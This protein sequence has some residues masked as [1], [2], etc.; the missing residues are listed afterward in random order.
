MVFLVFLWASRIQSQG[1]PLSQLCHNQS[2]STHAPAS[3][4]QSVCACASLESPLF[5]AFSQD[6]AV[7]PASSPPCGLVRGLE[8]VRRR[9]A[10]YI[11]THTHTVNKN[12]CVCLCYL[13][14]L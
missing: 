13:A 2:L 8:L 12:K 6:S 11:H 9:R 5:P 4:F 10:P 7:P 14:G 1:M 3:P